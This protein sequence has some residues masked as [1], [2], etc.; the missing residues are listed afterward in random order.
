MRALSNLG[1]EKIMLFPNLT[2]IQTDGL[3]V[4]RV[5]SLLKRAVFV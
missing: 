5:A 2:D 1:A 4:Y 3:S